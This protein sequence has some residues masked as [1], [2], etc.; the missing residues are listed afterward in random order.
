MCEISAVLATLEAI[1]KQKHLGTTPS[2]GRP[3]HSEGV[4]LLLLARLGGSRALSLKLVELLYLSRSRRL[5]PLLL[6]FCS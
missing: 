5:S 6:C 1:K 4:P 2:E 3:S